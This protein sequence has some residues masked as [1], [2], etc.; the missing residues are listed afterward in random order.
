MA[1]HVGAVEL[2]NTLA[3]QLNMSLPAS[4]VFDYPSIKDIAECVVGLTRT[5][6]VQSHSLPPNGMAVEAQQQVVVAVKSAVQHIIN[7]DIGIDEPLMNA[8][9]DSLGMFDL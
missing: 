3:A 4:L 2:R 9:V 5:A 1:L 6:S 7:A 8:G